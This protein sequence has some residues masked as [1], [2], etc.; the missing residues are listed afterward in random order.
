MQLNHIIIGAGR[1]GT[2]SLVAYLQQHPK[3]NFSSIKEVTYF[4]VVDHYN[5]GVEFLHS[6]F[7]R[8]EGILNATSDTYLLMDMD[9]PK[10][11]SDYNSELK[12]TVILREPL[13]R[14]HSNY[15]FSVNHGYIN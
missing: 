5:R 14:T 2:T 4:S 7:E 6:F 10:R 13:S 1:S 12:I 9:A 15:I 3:I 11:I 8:K